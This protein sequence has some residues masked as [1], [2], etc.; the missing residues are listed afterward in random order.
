MSDMPLMKRNGGKM[1]QRKPRT[2]S[3]TRVEKRIEST[4][5][6]N[7]HASAQQMKAMPIAPLALRR[8]VERNAAHA[9]KARYER[10]MNQ[11]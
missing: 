4:T 3:G 10:N 6:A 8:S 9:E 1:T 2:P 11:K 5:G 7:I